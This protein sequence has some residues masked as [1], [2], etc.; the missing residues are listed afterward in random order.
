MKQL[1]SE[2]GS[3]FCQF[4]GQITAGQEGFFGTPE[5][6]VCIVTPILKL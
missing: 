5:L 6:T 4:G 3:D 2:G 1:M